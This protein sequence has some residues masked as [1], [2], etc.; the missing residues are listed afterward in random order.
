VKRCIREDK[1]VRRQDKARESEVNG[2]AVWVVR[3]TEV[4]HQGDRGEH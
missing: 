4:S 3:G 2:A 1:Q